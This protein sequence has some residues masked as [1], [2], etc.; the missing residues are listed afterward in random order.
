MFATT[1]ITSHELVSDNPVHQRLFFA[2]AEAARR[3]GGE[4]LE[5][6]C[7]VGRGLD[8]LTDNCAHY[9]AVDKNEALLAQLRPRYPE[10]QFIHQHIPPL[11]GLASSAY[12]FVVS[13]QV[14]EH[15]ENDGEFVREI[16]RVLRPGGKLIL[17]TPNRLRSLTRNPWHVREYAA[18]ELTALVRQS[19]GQVETLG[20]AGNDRVMD[21]YEQNRRAVRRLTRLDVF[22]LQHRLPRTW[23]Q[24]PYDLLNRLNRKSLQKQHTGLVAD[25]THEDY[26]LTPD[27]VTCLDFFYVATK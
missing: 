8:V 11:T 27:V 4:L 7:G 22:D 13:F 9:T 5:I 25:I 1:E 14:I 15:I 20:V 26:H 19:F 2:Y 12:D 6:G 16:H 10:A 17:T 21:Y 18:A 23:L 24:V 3:V